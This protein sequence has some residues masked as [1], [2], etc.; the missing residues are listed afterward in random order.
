MSSILG[1]L[2]A[3]AKAKAKA[4]GTGAFDAAKAKVQGVVGAAKAKAQGVVAKVTGITPTTVETAVEVNQSRIV[5]YVIIGLA[6]IAIIAGGYFYFFVYKP[7]KPTVTANT[8]GTAAAN[9]PPVSGGQGNSAPS[10][11]SLEG[12]QMPSVP[13]QDIS[14]EETTFINLQPLSIKDTGFIGPYPSGAYDAVTATGNALKAGFRFLTLQIDYM[15]SA[16]KGFGTPGEPILLVRGPSGSLLSS[17]SG[18]ITEVAQTIANMAFQPSIPHNIEPVI[19]YLH[20]L[21]APSALKD[22]NVYL[23]FLSKIATAL[24][25]IAPMHL[26]LTPAG[27]FTRQKMADSLLT[28]PLKSLQGQVI[29]LSNADTSLFRSTSTSINKYS[30]SQDLD[31]WVNMRVFLDDEDSLGITQLPDSDA[32]VTAVVVDFDRVLALSDAKK[33]AFAAK[34]KRRYVIA[35]PSRL[36]NPSTADIGTAINILGVNAVPLDIFTSA[37]SVVMDITSEYANMPYHPKP[38]ALRNIG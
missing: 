5:M 26:G 30:P 36:D 31:F 29:V 14:P 34:G 24:N 35:M 15:D 16:K 20:V 37:T 10:V 6:L 17:N 1:N 13:P 11:Q 22:P 2:L 9:S 25:P 3:A 21:R 7:A 28:T 4:T 8:L 27:N 32:L 38:T 19:L 23:D 12:F 18:S 33:E